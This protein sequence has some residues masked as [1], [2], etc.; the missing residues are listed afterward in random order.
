MPRPRHPAHRVTTAHLQALYPWVA[1]GGLGPRG[2]YIGRDRFGGAFCYD[3]WELYERGELT[4]PNMLVIGQLGRGKSS[5]GKTYGH[6]Q[7]VFGRKLAVLDP[8][9]EWEPVA[10]IAKCA[11]V[12]L[13]PGGT[14]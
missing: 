4:G 12:R 9:A 2:V 11:P 8:K 7:T 13:T 1:E 3:P 6:R 5:F 10:R 14:I